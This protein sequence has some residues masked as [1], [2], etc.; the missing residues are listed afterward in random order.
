MG[1][2]AHAGS[3]PAP[4]VINFFTLLVCSDDL[5]DYSKVL[6]LMIEIIVRTY[7]PNDPF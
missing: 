4:G 7:P 6:V 2:V 5:L 3:N 1:V